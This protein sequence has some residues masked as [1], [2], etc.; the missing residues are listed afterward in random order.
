[1]AGIFQSLWC[2][3]CVWTGSLFT[4]ILLTWRYIMKTWMPTYGPM[5]PGEGKF[6]GFPS[7]AARTKYF[8]TYDLRVRTTAKWVL[9]EGVAWLVGL[10]V[11]F[12]IL[13]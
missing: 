2:L 5:P 11:L 12:L 8:N 3:P 1:M 4:V 6:G 13:R 7:E 9:I 10:A